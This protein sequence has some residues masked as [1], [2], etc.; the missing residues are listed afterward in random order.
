VPAFPP[1]MRAALAAL[2][3]LAASCAARD[4][5]APAQAVATPP[6]RPATEIAAPVRADS[7][8]SVRLLAEVNAVRA[9]RGLAVLRADARLDRMAAAQARAMAEGDYFA[10]RG[11]DG[12]GLGARLADFGYAYSFAAENLFAGADQAAE[13]VTGWMQSP[14]HRRNLL[15][16]EAVVAGAGYARRA[17]DGGRASYGSYWVLVLA[18][19]AEP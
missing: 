19:P 18:A 13:A 8:P 11:P 4:E 6:P 7:G 12:K 3:L 1:T 9:A 5:P 16:T 10:H 15:A 2:S 17:R 14:P